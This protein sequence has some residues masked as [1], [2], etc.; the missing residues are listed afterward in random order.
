[1]EKNENVNEIE[2]KVETEAE[3]KESSEPAK[4]E[5]EAEPAKAETKTEPALETKADTEAEAKVEPVDTIEVEPDTE[6]DTESETNEKKNIS[7]F[8][9]IKSD[10]EKGNFPKVDPFSFLP[11]FPAAAALQVMETLNDIFQTNK[12]KV[13]KLATVSMDNEIAKK[14]HEIEEIKNE[15]NDSES[16][17]ESESDKE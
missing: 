8:K 5:T 1:M 7:W 4:A 15:E 13:A 2:S 9:I 3:A 16:E 11:P 17:S 12:S 14:E 10:F 6:S